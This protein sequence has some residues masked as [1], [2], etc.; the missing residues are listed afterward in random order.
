MIAEL[1][2]KVVQNV[3]LNVKY[4]E[5][6][7]LHAIWEANTQGNYSKIIWMKITLSTHLAVKEI[8]IIMLVLNHGIIEDEFTAVLDI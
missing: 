8:L 1:D 3:S 7:I 6:I 5:G 4:T 2:L